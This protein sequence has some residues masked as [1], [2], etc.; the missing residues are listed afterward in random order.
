MQEV[1]AAH[2]LRCGHEWWVLL[3]LAQV[4]DDATREVSCSMDYLTARSGASSSDV[5][6]WLALL[7]E[8]GLIEVTECDDRHVACQI[9]PLPPRPPRPVRTAAPVE[10]ALYRIWGAADALL[11]IGISKDF[12]RRW[13]EHAKAQPWW[14]ERERMTVDKWYPTWEEARDAEGVAIKAERPKYNVKHAAPTA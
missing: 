9:Q 3:D 4:G 1:S 13:K 2:P 14:A 7:S 6:Y 10:T 8:Q 12:G 11:Y 5:S